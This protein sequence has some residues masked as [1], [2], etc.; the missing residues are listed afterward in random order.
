M[1]VIPEFSCPRRLLSIRDGEK[2]DT[3][4]DDTDTCS[5]CGSLGPKI[6]MAYVNS[7]GEIRETEK[8]YKI[9]VVGLDHKFYLQHLPE[10]QREDIKALRLEGNVRQETLILLTNFAEGTQCQET[11]NRKLTV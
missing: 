9:Y 4:L 2:L 1:I 5:Y 6:F 7:G 10:Q 3:W 11:Q 8:D